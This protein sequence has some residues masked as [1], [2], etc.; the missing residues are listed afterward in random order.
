MAN[1]NA[2]CSSSATRHATPLLLEWAFAPPRSDS[3]NSPE[4]ISGINHGLR[5][6]ILPRSDSSITK[7]DKPAASAL[8]PATVPMITETTGILPEQLANE[9]RTSPVAPR[10]GTPSSTR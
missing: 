7:S 4:A 5:M 9:S 10:A 2:C 6:N 3:S 1:S 8:V